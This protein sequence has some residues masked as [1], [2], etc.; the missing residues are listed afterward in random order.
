MPC[1]FIK[2]PLNYIGGKHKLLPQILPLFPKKITRCV[3]LFAGGCN[4]GINT[5][6]DTLIFNDNL[7]FLIAMYQALQQFNREELI[8]YIEEKIRFYQLSLHNEQGYKQL[9]QDY[10]QQK[11]HW[12][13]FY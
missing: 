8:L 5:P 3:D 11:N 1:A 4:V 7:S 2:S 13:Y 9:R 10:N 12:I 6:A